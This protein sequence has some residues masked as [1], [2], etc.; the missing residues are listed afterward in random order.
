[1]K[2][3]TY[4][5]DKKNLPNFPVTDFLDK[6]YDCKDCRDFHHIYTDRKNLNLNWGL[7]KLRNYRK[8]EL[9]RDD[10]SCNGGVL[11]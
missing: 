6:G 5:I 3:R 10:G 2:F 4:E 11:K 1:M 7:C 9:L 8:E